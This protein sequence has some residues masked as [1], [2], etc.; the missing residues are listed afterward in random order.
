LEHIEETEYLLE[1]SI[2]Q[3]LHEDSTEK[4][5]I[6]KRADLIFAFNFNPCQSFTD[7]RFGAPPGKYL[8][9]LDCDALKYGGTVGYYGSRPTLLWWTLLKQK[10]NMCSAFICQLAPLLSCARP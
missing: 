5:I 4:V 7:Y 2:P 3:L 10:V 1:A 6:F 9:I 8:M